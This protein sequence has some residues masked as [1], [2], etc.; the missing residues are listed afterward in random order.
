MIGDPIPWI[1]SEG[2]DL[3]IITIIIISSNKKN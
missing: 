2:I 3:V 1:R